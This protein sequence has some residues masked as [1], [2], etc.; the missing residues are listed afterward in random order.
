MYHTTNHDLSSQETT[1]AHGVSLSEEIPAKI[2]EFTL[3]IWRREV[4]IDQL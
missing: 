4:I 2:G 1:G 3:K